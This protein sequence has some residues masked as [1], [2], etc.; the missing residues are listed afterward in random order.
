MCSDE[1]F[2]L[3]PFF[4]TPYGVEYLLIFINFAIH[5]V[6][7]LLAVKMTRQAVLMFID[8]FFNL[9]KFINLAISFLGGGGGGR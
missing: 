2:T 5:Q 6:F 3:K 9:D 4:K 1:G 7:C 8:L